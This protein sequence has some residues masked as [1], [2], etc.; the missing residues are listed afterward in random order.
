MKLAAVKVVCNRLVRGATAGK[1]GRDRVAGWS[2]ARAPRPCSLG[3]VKLDRMS[4]GGDAGCSRLLV[5]SLMSSSL[6]P[7][8]S[9][10]APAKKPRP[11][12]ERPPLA[13]ALLD[14]VLLVAFLAL[15]F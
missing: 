11:P 8:E 4:P 3:E 6:L 7:S 10:P 2:D 9:A 14:A 15:T 12:A 1:V 5:E 13:P